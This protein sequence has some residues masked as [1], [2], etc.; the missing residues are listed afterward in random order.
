MERGWNNVP[1]SEEEGVDSAM[2]PD[3]EKSSML[4]S[5]CFLDPKGRIVTDAMLWK[6]RINEEE[7][8]EYLIDVPGDAADELL[9]HLKM[10]KLRR[11]KV[12]IGD[13]SSCM[14]VH[15]VYGTL[16]DGGSPPGYIAAVDPRHPSLGMRVLNIGNDD[17]NTSTT[18]HEERTSQFA[19]LM[20][21]YF[22][23]SFGTYNVIRKLA[24]IAEGTELT[25]KT[26]LECNH[27]FL[28]S[29]SFNK[30]CYLGQELT[31]RTNFTGVIRK[32]IMPCVIVDTQ[33]EV[34]R[35]WLWASMLQEHGLDGLDERAKA[36]LMIDEDD[37]EEVGA[38]SEIMPPLLP[39]LSA[40]G[41]GG[42]VAMLSGSVLPL[43][44]DGVA[45][46]KKAEDEYKTME[47]ASKF[48]QEISSIA[49]ENSKIVDTKD[50]RTIGKIVSSPA[51]G[52]TVLLAQM[53]MDRVGLLGGDNKW[54][55]V[56]RILI[57]D[58]KKELRY[59]PFMPLWWP[60]VDSETGKG[61]IVEEEEN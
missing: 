37:E 23:P 43:P 7:E 11:S 46:E 39:R 27:D 3:N 49:G 4:Y 20:S 57:G 38:G 52:T 29:I 2:I 14:S 1:L 34:P 53:R 50:G 5:A 33:M 47:E 60:D 28:N 56:N 12:T 13:E 42:L 26:P 35:P 10:Y 19:S 6:R 44:D 58:S 15:T 32:R 54:S 25:N 41:A 17:N 9:A 45:E 18:T 55:R 40:P 61:K 48:V 21:D 36:A 31:A 22:P 30:G 59:L 16:A 51:P 24:G 8:E